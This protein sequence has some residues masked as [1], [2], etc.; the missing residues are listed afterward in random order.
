MSSDS[1]LIPSK[2]GYYPLCFNKDVFSLDTF[3]VDAF[4]ADCRK[5]VPLESVLADLK[6]Y[7]QSLD[8]ELL[9]L[10]NKDYADFVNLSSH[11]VGLEK[12]ISDVRRPLL[13][14]EE[15]VLV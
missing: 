6:E 8:G 1:S 11:L 15:K 7:S 5:R 12:I 4:I 3:K 10:I 2:K 9:E 13:D 14:V